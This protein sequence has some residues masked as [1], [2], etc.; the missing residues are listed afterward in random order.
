MPK[1]KTICFANQKGGVGKTTSAVNISACIARSGKK[2]L[3]V[4]S[5]PQGNAT[6]GIGIKKRNTGATVYDLLIGRNKA[7][8]AITPTSYDNLFVIP[9]SINLVGAELE[10]VDENKREYRLREA[11]NEIKIDFD[12]IIIDCPPSLGLV[13]INSLTAADAIIVPLLCEYYSLEGLSQ[14]TMTIKHIKRLY[15]PELEL[16][17]VLINMFDGRLNLT[18]QVLEE[19][20][21]YFSDKLFKTPIPR[22]V[23]I[24]EAPSYGMSIIDY[25]RHSKGS[26]A[27]ASVAREIMERCGQR[28]F[29]SGKDL[30]KI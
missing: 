22:N 21:K 28:D 6:S 12:Y 30:V 9:S 26:A 13:T 3:L 5:D 4:D 19:I 1:F 2:V 16:L 10:L 29:I 27:Y 7:N 17:G 24:S 8:E 11:L 15:N 14:L 25:D 23:K 18:V 20:K